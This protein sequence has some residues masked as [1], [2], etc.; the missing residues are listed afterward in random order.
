[1]ILAAGRGER[2]RPL[3]DTI[4]K[5]LLR[6]GNKMLIEYHLDKL[7]RAGFKE[8]VINHAYLGDMIENALGDGTC[9]GVTICYS[10]ETIKLETAGGIANALPYLTADHRNRPFLVVN[11]DIYCSIDFSTLIPDLVRL[12]SQS[13]NDLAYLLLVNNPSHHLEGDF[14]LSEQGRITAT[15]QTKLTFSGIGIYRPQLFEQVAIN[16]PTRLA[17]L[18]HQAIANYQISGQLFSGEWIDIGTPDRLY[19]LDQHLRSQPC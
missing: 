7:A 3:T 11:G 4:P 6:V 13:N 15:G 16:C 10:K 12:N 18:L 9:Y 17:P 5:P 14:Y 8:I 2:M 1:M 19:A